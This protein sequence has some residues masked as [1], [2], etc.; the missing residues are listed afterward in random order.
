M[1]SGWIEEDLAW[2]AELIAALDVTATLEH[3][4]H[5]SSRFGR[6]R[7]SDIRWLSANGGHSESRYLVTWAQWLRYGVTMALR[8]NK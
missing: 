3:R 7:A 5:L 1:P 4:R 8:R 2:R 6:T